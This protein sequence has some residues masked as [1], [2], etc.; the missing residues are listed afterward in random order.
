MSPS[1]CLCGKT[2]VKRFLQAL[3]AS[4][5]PTVVLSVAR[6]LATPEAFACAVPCCQQLGGWPLVLEL[7]DAAKLSGRVDLVLYNACAGA[8]AW[9]EALQVFA[10]MERDRLFMDT[11]SYNSAISSCGKASQSAQA[12]ELFDDVLNSALQ[13]SLQSYAS[14]MDA[15]NRG[16]LWTR[17]LDFFERVKRHMEPND[18]IWGALVQACALAGWQ[19]GLQQLEE[20]R[21]KDWQVEESALNAVVKACGHGLQ[22]RSAIGLLAD[23]Q[24]Q[25]LVSMGTYTT[26][27]SACGSSSK[28]QQ[29]LLVGSSLELTGTALDL[30]ACSTL[31]SVCERASNWPRALK[32]FYK[33]DC[34]DQVSVH[35]ALRACASAELWADALEIFQSLE[36]RQVEKDH[37]SY[38]QTLKACGAHWEL[39]LEL[40]SQLLS[41]LAPDLFTFGSML[42][43]CER[44][45]QW[46]LCL[47]LLESSELRDGYI[48]G[49]V[50]GSC[51]QA[52]QW[53]ITLELFKEAKESGLELNLVP[54]TT[55][56]DA[57]GLAGCWEE[58][59]DLLEDLKNTSEPKLLSYTAAAAACSR[60]S[61]WFRVL[62]LVNEAREVSMDSALSELAL[63]ACERGH[64]WHSAHVL[65]ELSAEALLL[66]KRRSRE[67]LSLGPIR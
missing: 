10:D 63:S 34:L 53:Q 17:S 16:G 25:R 32:L 24:Q 11:I 47:Q 66:A 18:Y 52:K 42:A 56:L 43:A 29:A 9:P 64:V 13:V 51:A 46:R 22:W 44:G 21:A 59:L 60:Q 62:K 30:L 31:T 48:Y 6:Q 35:V 15:A 37:M 28:W 67:A 3:S 61:D 26:V 36:L 40:Y 5:E 4:L 33:M 27:M 57:Y 58:A 38:T 49:C 41:R 14:A 50:M 2:H 45:G 39:A 65:A 19:E 55:A 12:L 20:M 23:A 1:L 8:C 7:L 54:Y